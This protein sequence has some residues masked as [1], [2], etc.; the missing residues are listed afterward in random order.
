MRIANNVVVHNPETSLGKIDAD[1]LRS[2]GWPDEVVQQQQR[3]QM[4][5]DTAAPAPAAVTSSD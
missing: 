3:E 5:H 4:S 2:H 1:R